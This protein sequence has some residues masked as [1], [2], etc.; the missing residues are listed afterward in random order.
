M[1]AHLTDS[2]KD[3]VDRG[4]RYEKGSVTEA[5]HAASKRLIKRGEELITRSPL[6]R[7][8]SGGT[9]TRK[10]VLNCNH[11]WCFVKYVVLALCPVRS[12]LLLHA[13]NLS[14]AVRSCPRCPPPAGHCMPWPKLQQNVHKM[15]LVQ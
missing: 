4:K 3:L 14:A 7:Y 9:H 10:S 11:F 12:K 13:P 1:V 2:A 8:V 15:Q 6:Y 5:F